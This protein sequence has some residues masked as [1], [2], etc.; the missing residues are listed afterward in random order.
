MITL[1]I[2]LA[3]G[4]WKP[5]LRRLF[6]ALQVNGTCP[7]FLKKQLALWG[8]CFIF[9]LSWTAVS[10]LVILTDFKGAS[11]CTKKDRSMA[12]IFKRWLYKV[13]FSSLNFLRHISNGFV[14]LFQE[15]G[16]VWSLSY[17][18]PSLKSQK[19]FVWILH[20]ISWLHGL[21]YTVRAVHIALLWSSLT[22]ALWIK[23]RFQYWLVVSASHVNKHTY[24]DNVNLNL[25]CCFS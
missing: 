15:P 18:Q 5:S 11:Q 3:D 8:H 1:S 21:C 10:S 16:D 17:P 24:E 20:T 12:G 7:S 19:C 2:A 14:L 22:S 4:K 13:K 6:I 9:F 23:S 25:K